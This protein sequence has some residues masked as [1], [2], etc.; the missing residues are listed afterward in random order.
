MRGE[1]NNLSVQVEENASAGLAKYSAIHSSIS[2]QSMGEYVNE[3]KVIQN[4]KLELNLRQF[5]HSGVIHQ[6]LPWPRSV[7]CSRR[8]WHGNK[9]FSVT[10]PFSHGDHKQLVLSFISHR[11]S[12]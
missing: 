11:H 2:N 4:M 8:A 9:R 12:Q 1:H 6:L 3:I 7:D 10:E 5:R